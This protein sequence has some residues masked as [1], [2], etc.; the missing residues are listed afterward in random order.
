MS[1]RDEI[2]SLLSAA[3][4]VRPQWVDWAERD[5]PASFLP[6]E[7]RWLMELARNPDFRR[8][9][10]QLFD[11]GGCEHPVWL[12][13][14]TLVKALGTG[15][16]VDYLSSADAPGGLVPVRCMNRRRSRCA[17]CSWLYQGDAFQLARA[18]V[19]GGK[20]VPAEVAGHP[21]AFVTLTAPSF[22]PVHR[23]AKK[24]GDPAECRD[25]WARPVCVHGASLRCDQRHSP[26]DRVVGQ[27]FCSECYDYAGAVLWNAQASR[28][29]KALMDNAYHHLARHTDVSR[30]RVRRLVRVEYVRV[31]EFQAR[32]SV[33][34]HAVM[35]LDGT[36]GASSAPPLWASA[37]VLCE[38]IESAARVSR[39]Q[40]DAGPGG[41]RVLRFGGQMLPRPVE[42]GGAASPEALAGYLAGYVIKGT[43]DA[44]GSDVPVTHPSAIED[45]GKTEHARALMRAAWRL[46]AVPELEPLHLRRW[47]HMLGYRGRVVTA[48]RGFSVT[49]KALRAARAAFHAGPAADTGETVRVA[50]WTYA[51][52]GYNDPRMGS[53][54]ESVREDIEERREMAREALADLRAQEALH[55]W[56]EPE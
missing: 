37:E 32:G 5:A 51:G 26:G 42:L 12:R 7:D 47:C 53:L 17:S 49:F 46:G 2:R 33:H 24:P 23:A 43:E 36:D 48:S 29:W 20:G 18:G 41:A 44:H 6:L 39:V 3:S 54:A 13:G 4:S 35:R 1:D 16:I 30:S 27:A 52:Q 11:I 50:N 55:D 22:G 38:C 28:L 40:V 34:F 25:R 45:A 56:A 8:V 31:A 14:S 21:L 15:E 10:R 9:Q 19:A